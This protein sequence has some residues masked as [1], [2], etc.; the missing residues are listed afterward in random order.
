MV[1]ITKVT[2]PLKEK[3]IIKSWHLIDV[4]G[5][6]LGRIS[7]KIASLLQGKHK[8]NYVPYLDCGDYIVVINARKIKVTGK[9]GLNKNYN[10]YS[11]Y[12]GGLKKISFS[13]L[14]SE[15]PEMII[16]HAVSGMLP[17][18]KLRDRRMTRLFVYAN[19]EHPY[20]DKFKI[21]NP[22]LKA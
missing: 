19:D 9:K 13:K 12:P 14:L 15:K 4:S 2:K 22:K 3:E 1:N 20:R 17:K 8:L 6:V 7:S 21:Q 10:R 5:Q 18:N 11:G 16:S